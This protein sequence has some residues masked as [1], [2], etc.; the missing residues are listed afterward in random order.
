MKISSTHDQGIPL[1]DKNEIRGLKPLHSLI[2]VIGHVAG[3]EI[4]CIS[5]VQD[6]S[7]VSPGLLQRRE[8]VPPV[9]IIYSSPD[10]NPLL[11]LHNAN[12]H[13]R[14]TRRM[15]RSHTAIKMDVFCPSRP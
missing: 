9:E 3:M 7:I 8:G 4:G 6:D 2:E 10:V 5:I 12:S 11:P 13:A 14:T 1:S 15:S